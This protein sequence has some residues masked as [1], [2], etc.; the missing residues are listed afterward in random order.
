[1]SFFFSYILNRDQG[2]LAVRA[3]GK[4]VAHVIHEADQVARRLHEVGQEA[5][6]LRALAVEHLEQLGDLDNAACADDA[7][8]E[9]L[10]NGELEADRVGDVDVVHQR[11]VARVA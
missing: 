9:S 10:G 2:H 4:A 1:M 3:E 8:P 7:D 5:N 11:P 6:A